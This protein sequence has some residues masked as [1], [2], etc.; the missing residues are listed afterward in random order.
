MQRIGKKNPTLVEVSELSVK[1]ANALV[2]L[3]NKGIYIGPEFSLLVKMQRMLA[4]A[5]GQLI[6][7]L[8]NKTPGATNTRHYLT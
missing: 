3:T 1:V 7:E 5:Q 8:V 2:E 6:K 4:E